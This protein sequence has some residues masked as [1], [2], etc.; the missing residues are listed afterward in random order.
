LPSIDE[1]AGC[2]V[3]RAFL[4]GW[5]LSG[6]SGSYGSVIRCEL[7]R[8]LCMSPFGPKPC[9]GRGRFSQCWSVLGTNWARIW[10][11]QL[12]RRPIRGPGSPA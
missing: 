10:R 8:R 2:T 4:A 7:R 6:G 3:G 11:D 12:R 1:A 9:P 5:V